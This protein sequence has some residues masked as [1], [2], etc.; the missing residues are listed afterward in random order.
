MTATHVV[1]RQLIA[2]EVPDFPRLGGILLFLLLRYLS[3]RNVRDIVYPVV[4]NNV[5]RL[6]R[7]E[8]NMRILE[9]G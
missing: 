8:A 2:P 7:E 9:L 4:L 1:L 6:R 3:E 5:R